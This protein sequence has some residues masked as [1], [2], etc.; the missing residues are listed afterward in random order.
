[1]T[2]KSCFVALALIT[3]SASSWAQ[4]TLTGSQT[5]D[6][7]I[8]DNDLSGLSET[9]VLGSGIQS[10]TDVQLTLDV[11]GTANYQPFNGDYYAYLTDGA[12]TVVL[13]DRVGTAPGSTVRDVFGYN[14]K[15][16]DVTLA[17]GSPDIHNYQSG[18]YSLNAAGQLTGTWAPDGGALSAFDGEGSAGD[19]TLFIADES[20]GGIG[21]LDSWSLEVTGTPATVAP[22]VPDNTSTMGL[23]LLGAGSLAFWSFRQRR[24]AAS[25]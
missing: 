10:I 14:N 2:T 16:F 11:G 21:N 8:P 23:L 19:W 22:G 20:E 9:I 7:I 24:L 6:T 3:F 1:M 4:T 13:L 25:R 5:P 15:G 18:S 12:T 17:D